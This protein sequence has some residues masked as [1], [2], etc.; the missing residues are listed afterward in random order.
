[1][2]G[3]GRPAILGTGTYINDTY[4]QTPANGTWQKKRKGRLHDD[5]QGGEVYFT[6]QSDWLYTQQ[7]NG[8]PYWF[9]RNLRYSVTESSQDSNSLT[10]D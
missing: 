1:M 3:W 7:T 8:F 6:R 10:M 9:A 5:Q 4:Y 2:S